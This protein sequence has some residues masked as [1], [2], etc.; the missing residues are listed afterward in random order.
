MEGDVEQANIPAGKKMQLHY[1]LTCQSPTVFFCRITSKLLSTS[2]WLVHV[3]EDLG[4]SWMASGAH[5]LVREMA[6]ERARRGKLEC[7]PCFARLCTLRCKSVGFVSSLLP[8]FIGIAEGKFRL[9]WCGRL[10]AFLIIATVSASSWGKRSGDTDTFTCTG[11]SSVLT[12]HRFPVL[13][14]SF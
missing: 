6:G 11:S 7:L 10:I 14:K 9:M 1:R 8:S 12:L 4:W 5:A 13:D 3:V 2:L